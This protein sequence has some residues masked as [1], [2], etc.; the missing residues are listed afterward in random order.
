MFGILLV[1]GVPMGLMGI[2][3]FMSFMTCTLESKKIGAGL[4]SC[5]IKIK[6]AINNDFLLHYYEHKSKPLCPLT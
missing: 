2:L 3:S 4:L 6:A 1:D 5:S